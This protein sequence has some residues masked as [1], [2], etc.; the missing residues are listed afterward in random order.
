M[1]SSTLPIPNNFDG[2]VL[3]YWGRNIV[4]DYLDVLAKMI[5]AQLH[6]QEGKGTALSQRPK[7]LGGGK[8]K[9]CLPA[10]PTEGRDAVQGK[11]GILGAGV[12]GLYTALILDSL[13]IKY[14]ILEASK[15]TGGR[16][17][18]HKFEKGNNYD[19]FVCHSFH[20]HYAMLT[21]MPTDLIEPSGRMSVL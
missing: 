12:G 17:F 2:D 15:R 11:V 10:L 19:Y 1:K 6:A 18:T 8:P 21:M 5:A 14:E 9:D 3:G 13:G 4:E 16:L 7:P 20:S